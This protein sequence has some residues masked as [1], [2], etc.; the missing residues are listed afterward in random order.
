MRRIFLFLFFCSSYGLMAQTGKIQGTV[1]TSDGVPAEYIN[2][3]IKGTT[4]GAIT[5]GKGAFEINN[6]TVG[7]HTI[8]VSFVGLKTR[9]L[10]IS[11]E[12]GET[13]VMADIVL[14]ENKQRLDEVVI[15]GSR[16]YKVDEISSSLRLQIP[17]LET[18][19]NIQVITG[20]IIGDQQSIDMLEGVSRNVSGVQMIEHWGNFARVNM[21]GFKI[22]AFRNGMNVEMPWGPLVEDMSLVERIEFVK[23][24]AGF[25]VS[26]GEPGGLYNVV[27]KKPVQDQVNEVSLTTGSF[28]TLRGTVDVGGKLNDDGDFLYRLNVMSLTKGSH[29]AY[30]FNKRYTIAPSVSYALNN[31]T[32]LTAQYIYQYSQMSVVGAAYVFSP[33]GFADLPRN[34]T[35]GDPS[36]DPTN[37]NEHNGFI[38]LSHKI[39]ND[40]KLTAQ[41]GYLRYEQIGSSLWPISLDSAGNMIRGLT[42]WDALNE[43]KMGQ[44][45]VNGDFQTGS[46][47][48]KFMAAIDLSQKDYYADWFQG[49]PL[50]AGDTFNI[51][52]PVYGVPSNEMPVFDRTKSI[53]QRSFGSYSGTS[54]HRSSSIYIQ[55]QL[56]FF[57]EKLR[58]TLAGRYTDYNGWTYGNVSDDQVFSPRVALSYSLAKKTSIY[59]LYDQSFVPQ[60]GTSVEG[61]AFV[62]ERAN[63]LEGG[64]KRDW[65][66]GRW[67]STLAVYQIRKENVLVGHPD[68]QN[69]PNHQIQLGEVQSQGIELDIQGE[70]VEGLKI[71]INYANTNVEITEDTNEAF[72]GNRIAGHAR[73]MTNGWL[74]YE[75]SQPDLRGFGVSIGYQYQVDRSSWNWGADNDSVLP[76]YFRLD[77]ALSWKSDDVS[78]GLNINNLLNDYLYSGSGYDSYYYWQTE[79]GTNFRLNIAYNF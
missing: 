77:G 73:H 34:F 65:A 66:D 9:E 13:V 17:L 8:V 38:N 6:V 58:L 29:R 23:G 60:T 55:D 41:I 10:L 35:L 24:P 53:R 21:R 57:E 67:N 48:H 31:S 4:K 69:Y 28:N 46:V 51:Y 27:T 54:G 61:D 12:E 5:D 3:V 36:I 11:V 1:I 78:V 47:N 72:I 44:V 19:Q 63:N 40:W 15:S 52:N 76:D 22:P 33:K 75:F 49:G 16:G 56:G 26:S 50:A 25:M 71:V 59:G 62:P 70:I 20:K 43:S 37:I 14:H 18:P 2:V 79:P 45:Y 74:H 42:I 7:E 39:N 64:I 68:K 30:E 32:S